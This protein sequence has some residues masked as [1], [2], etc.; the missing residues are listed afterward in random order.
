VVDQSFAV[1]S[2]IGTVQYLQRT[3]GNHAVSDWL[4]QRQPAPQ[5]HVADA[6]ARGTA[7]AA[8]SINPRT[9][10]DDAQR[11][12]L[13]ELVLSQRWVGPSDETWLEHCWGALDADGLLRFANGHP[14]LWDRCRDRGAELE[15]L[16]S[17]SIVRRRFTDEVIALARHHLRTNQ[18]LVDTE[19]QAVGL[20]P[21]GDAQQAPTERQSARLA[22]I[23]S[24]A[25]TL[26][27]LQRAQEAARH[28]KVG[29][30]IGDGGDVDPDWTGRQVKFQV[31]FEPTGPPPLTVD[32]GPDVPPGDIFTSPIVPYD[33]VRDGYDAASR[34]ISGLV[35]ATPS[36]FGLMRNGSSRATEAFA[37]TE[38][39]QGARAT[40]GRTLGQVRQDIT[41]T[42]EY[43]GD[44]LD[45]LDLTPLHEQLHTGTA[46]VGAIHW[47]GG[48]GWRIASDAARDHEVSRAL[49]RLALQHVTQLAF[50]F[51][52]F[53]SGVSLLLLLGTGAAAA[54]VNAYG[55]YRDAQSLTAAE[56]T[57]VAPGTDIVRPGS[58]A[59]ARMQAEADAVAFALAAIALGAAGLQAWRAGADV[60]ALRVQAR[61]LLRQARAEGRV[62]VNIG[63]AGAPHEPPG[64]INLNPQVPG[65]QRAGI[66]NLVQAR[67][68]QIGELFPP[69]SVDRIEGHNLAGGAIDWNRVADGSARVLRPG[70]SLEIYFRG[71]HDGAQQLAGALRRNGF[72]D[73]T[74]VSDVLITA[75]R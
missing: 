52:P 50:L 7:D 55:S 45:P 6:I 73:V 4:A 22:A 72:R 23:Q 24:A 38:N 16:P 12:S 15:D 47:T 1:R 61:S 43:L 34:A 46:P 2:R 30:R 28:S 67:G 36:L 44:R 56:G 11:A 40:L 35:A 27:N 3:V 41:R 54:G 17:V 69:A 49:A 57:S 58:A 62:V 19:L 59:F 20:A 70:G 71:A 29:W 9:S 39:P 33:E 63:G 65:T 14:G 31:E 48:L 51:A 68:E 37:D 60:R 74:V 5:P 8:K 18:R 42:N 10:L 53:T 32:P 25:A 64:A 21:T 66:P 26:S 13:I 75:T